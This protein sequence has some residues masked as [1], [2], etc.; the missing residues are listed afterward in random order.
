MTRHIALLYLLAT[1]ADG[2]FHMFG[3]RPQGLKDPCYDDNNRPKRCVPNFV[4]AAYGKPVIAT[5]TCGIRQP[6]R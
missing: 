2:Y 5:S 3:P 4:N 6:S 1:V